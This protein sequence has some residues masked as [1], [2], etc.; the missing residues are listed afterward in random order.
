MIKIEFILF[1]FIDKFWLKIYLFANTRQTQLYAC[2]IRYAI[3]G[4][5]PVSALQNGKMQQAMK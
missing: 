3:W 1:S 2:D 4:Y 5:L